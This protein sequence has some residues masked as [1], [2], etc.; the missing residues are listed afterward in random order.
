LGKKWVSYITYNQPC[1][2][3][4]SKTRALSLSLTLSLCLEVGRS[5]HVWKW[6]GLSVFGSGPV[7]P[8]L[9]MGRSLQGWGTLGLSRDRRTFSHRA[10]P[11]ASVLAPSGVQRGPLLSALRSGPSSAALELS[12]IP[13][14]PVSQN[15]ALGTGGSCKL[16]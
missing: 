9:E 8:C 2:Q 4:R 10:L 12:V 15:V 1:L 11:G 13:K 5:L 3:K 16:N 14:A 7:S 6:A